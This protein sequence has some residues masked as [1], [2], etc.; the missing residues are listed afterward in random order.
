M[1]FYQFIH[2]IAVV[3]TGSFT[4]GTDRASV[5]QSAFS[6]SVAKLEAEF[7]VQLLDRRR[8]PVVPTE[9]GERL[10]EAGKAILQICNAV[11]G[12][13]E[14]IARPKLLRI[15]ILQ[16]L[17]SRDVSSLLGSFRRANPFVAIETFDGVGEQL[18]GLLPDRRVDI[19]TIFDE[20]SASKSPS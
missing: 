19:L 6:A 2:F 8:S 12:E 4:K 1:E 14:S 20:D 11:R 17:S 9:A 10:L 13:L 16:S 18:L 15:G 7:D 5:S 3:E